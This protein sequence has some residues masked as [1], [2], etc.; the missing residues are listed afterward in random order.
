M[1][2]KTIVS[3]P[4]FEITVC[5]ADDTLEPNPAKRNA[6][7][8]FADRSTDPEETV[9]L[10]FETGNNV[11]LVNMKGAPSPEGALAAAKAVKEKLASYNCDE[12]R[13]FIAGTGDGAY[14]ALYAAWQES[15]L[16]PLGVLV[17][18]PIFPVEGAESPLALC[19]E[20]S[21]PALIW[22]RGGDPGC[23]LAL[24]TA[25]AV[26]DVRHSVHYSPVMPQR[27]IS[28]EIAYW[29]CQRVKKKS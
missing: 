13:I 10:F 9:A 2:F 20:G 22:Q 21:T 15:D 16:A 17:E 27:Q 6:V 14:A 18:D 12:N 4:L 3:E 26:A 1:T 8:Y 5:A 29:I 11:F 25:L 7:I 24:A 19:R 23:T 28:K